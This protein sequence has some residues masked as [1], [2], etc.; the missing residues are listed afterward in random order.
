MKLPSASVSRIGLSPAGP[1]QLCLAHKQSISTRNE[2]MDCF[3]SLAM[4]VSGRACHT[5]NRHRPPPGRR[6]APP[7]DRLRRA[8]QYSETSVM[9][10]KS[11]GVPDT[12]HA[13][14]MTALCGS[15]GVVIASEAKQSTLSLRGKMD[16]FA[17][18]VIGL[19]FARPVGSQ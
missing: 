16:C 2:R 12:P 8:I 13:R 15:T 6:I 18:P 11:C 19:A 14:G 9:E 4:T 7:D 17:E 3:A 5:S 10:S 1:R